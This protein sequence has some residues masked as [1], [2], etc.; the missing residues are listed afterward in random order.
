MG[1]YSWLRYCLF[2]A[3]KRN[4]CKEKLS[5]ARFPDV[6]GLSFWQEVEEDEA[7]IEALVEWY[8]EE[9]LYQWYKHSQP[10]LCISVT[11]IHPLHTSVA[12]KRHQAHVQ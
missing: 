1:N 5:F 8:L 3:R 2:A 11:Y 6:A 9:N 12:L 4:Y 10:S 7:E